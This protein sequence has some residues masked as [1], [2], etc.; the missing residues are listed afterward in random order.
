MSTVL[1]AD[2]ITSAPSAGSNFVIYWDADEWR[3]LEDANK[4]TKASG[5]TLLTCSQ[6]SGSN[7]TKSTPVLTADLLG[8]WREEIIWREM[9]NAAL[10]VYATTDVT[11]RRI[12]TLMHDP[13]YRA[14]VAFEQSGYNQ[15]PHTGFRIS[16]NMADPPQPNI[17]VK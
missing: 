17:N 6:C 4:I 15:P 8:D 1:C 12:Y 7:G 9:S 10:R 2:G 11:T 14:Q 16:P 5:T 13:T 3:E